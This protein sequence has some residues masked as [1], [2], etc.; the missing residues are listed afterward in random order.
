MA[1]SHRG[2]N[3]G[4]QGRWLGRASHTAFKRLGSLIAPA[5]DERGLAV[6]LAPL[7]DDD[8]RRASRLIIEING[9][10][11]TT[12]RSPVDLNS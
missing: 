10:I 12:W 4:W 8:I 9:N 7:S 5:N 2:P 3:T 1:W 6:D 11:N